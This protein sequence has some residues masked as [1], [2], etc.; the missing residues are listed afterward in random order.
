MGHKMDSLSFK[1]NLETNPTRE[2]EKKTSGSIAAVSQKKSL[3]DDKLYE[4]VTSLQEPLLFGGDSGSGQPLDSEPASL[5]DCEQRESKEGERGA[6]SHWRYSVVT[7]STSIRT[8]AASH[9]RY[10][11]VMSKSLMVSVATISSEEELCGEAG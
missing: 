6:A 1:K 8:G 2:T 7:E 10:S 5:D 3:S 9:W 11:V 4:M